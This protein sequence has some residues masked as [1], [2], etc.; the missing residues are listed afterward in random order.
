MPLWAYHWSNEDTYYT[1]IE[2]RDVTE[3]IKYIERV[4]KK[5]FNG[6]VWL[7]DEKTKF[8]A[9]DNNWIIFC[10]AVLHREGEAKFR[11]HPAPYT[12]ILY[13]DEKNEGIVEVLMV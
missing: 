10:V 3:A 7:V 13:F 11:F 1:P 12:K 8:K 6:H 4:W 2:A 9:P 5:P